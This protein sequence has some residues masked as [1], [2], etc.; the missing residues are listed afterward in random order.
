[1]GTDLDRREM[2]YRTEVVRLLHCAR[3]EHCD[4]RRSGSVNIRVILEDRHSAER[5][6][7]RGDVDD[8]RAVLTREVV[9]VADY[10][11]ILLRADEG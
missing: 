9:D 4:S 5:Q 3:G 1:M 6:R 10:E 2:R 8:R 7:T 11:Q